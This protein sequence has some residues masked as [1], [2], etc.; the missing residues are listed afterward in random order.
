MKFPENFL[1]LDLVLRLRAPAGS[2][3]H[4]GAEWIGFTPS[5]ILCIYAFLPFDA[6]AGDHRR[7]PG[8]PSGQKSR[9]C[10]GDRRRQA[11]ISSAGIHLEELGPA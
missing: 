10:L 11:G 4:P 1:S 5:S 7:T 2:R 3:D 9:L 8:A 6:L